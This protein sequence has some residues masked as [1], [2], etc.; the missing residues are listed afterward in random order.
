MSRSSELRDT[1][2]LAS[3]LSDVTGISFSFL[4]EGNQHSEVDAYIVDSVGNKVKIQHTTAAAE[5]LINRS[6]NSKLLKTGKGHLAPM[7]DSINYASIVHAIQ[8]KI[9]RKYEDE[10]GLVLLLEASRPIIDPNDVLLNVNI[11]PCSF[12]GIYYVQVPY[13]KEEQ[14][15]VVTLKK[16]W[17]TP[18][19]F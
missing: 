16:Y 10:S 12:A 17:D 3:R 2:F 7:Y 8:H 13:D 6:I 14:G 9:D 19:I 15:Y 5:M 1:S 4:D 11:P 18:A